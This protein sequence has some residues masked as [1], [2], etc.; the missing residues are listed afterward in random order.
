M[1]ISFLGFS[2]SID[3]PALVRVLILAC[4]VPIVGELLF[5]SF[6]NELHWEN[7]PAHTVVEAWGFFA[8]I[9]LAVLL[10]L[11]RR[12]NSAYEHHL[13]I[14]SGL[15]VMSILDGF[16]AASIPSNTFVWLRSIATLGGGIFFCMVWLPVQ[17]T[18][19]VRD[20]WIVGAT[21]AGAVLLG[22]ASMAWLGHQWFRSCW[23]KEILAQQLLL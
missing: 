22:A 10:I 11:L 13:W 15:L 1:Q 3:N 20:R 14:V 18:S 7:I 12:Y 4:L 6:G 9:I 19:R 2:F 21:S 8:G 16:H 23:R 17:L 5:H